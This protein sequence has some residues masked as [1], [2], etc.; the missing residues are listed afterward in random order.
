MSPVRSRRNLWHFSSPL[1]NC[2]IEK[3]NGDGSMI[4]LAAPRPSAGW[5]N[6]DLRWRGNDGRLLSDGVPALA[7]CNRRYLG[8]TRI[9]R[10]RF[11]SK[12]RTLR[13]PPMHHRKSPSRSL[14]RKAAEDLV[15]QYRIERAARR[16]GRFALLI[17]AVAAIAAV[18]S[19]F[20]PKYL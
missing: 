3:Q 9:H 11:S 14:E 8:G 1:A 17:F 18:A 13:W 15:M 19:L 6:L 4:Y 7:D 10:I 5:S 16:M 12:T 20:R 2:G